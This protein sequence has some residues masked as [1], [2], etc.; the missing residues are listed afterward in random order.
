MK[1]VTEVVTIKELKDMAADIDLKPRQGN[2]TRNVDELKTR[3][4][5]I[6]IVNKPVED[7]NL[8]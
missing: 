4:K 6:E 8:S 2:R 1:I 5:I 3:N 7:E